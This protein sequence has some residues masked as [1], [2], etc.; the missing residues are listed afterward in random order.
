M[1]CKGGTNIDIYTAL[2]PAHIFWKHTGIAPYSL[3]RKSQ[4]GQHYAVSLYDKIMASTVILSIIALNIMNVSYGVKF[5]VLSISAMLK[6][7]MYNLASLS[8]LLN[9]Y[10][11]KDDVITSIENLMIADSAIE[12]ETKIRACP[13]RTRFQIVCTILLLLSAV[14]A[15]F[16]F[17]FFYE[18]P[19]GKFPVL[20]FVYY[21][22]YDILTVSVLT[23]LL[24]F[25]TQIKR[26]FHTINNY[27]KTHISNRTSTYQQRKTLRNRKLIEIEKIHRLLRNTSKNV[28]KIFEVVI[29]AKVAVTSMYILVVIFKITS[30]LV[31]PIKYYKEIYVIWSSIHFF[32][33][34]TAVKLFND[35]Q[36]EVR[37]LFR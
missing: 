24:Y 28:N 26:M 5:D 29:L 3:K 10:Y 27:L 19:K 20:F 18:N 16:L 13:I 1:S 15:A 9:M 14:M 35:I 7:S 17:S 6:R 25:L 23:M 4:P 37:N 11:Y 30:N 21:Y 33:V 36:K 31:V 2:V 32:H 12:K 8:Y 22:V 34:V